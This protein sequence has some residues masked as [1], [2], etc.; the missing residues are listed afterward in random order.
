MKIV[1]PENADVGVEW[2]QED[3]LPKHPFVL[4]YQTAEE[5]VGAS[6]V[7]HRELDEE[8]TFMMMLSPTIGQGEGKITDEQILP[9][10]VVFCV[11]TSGS[12]IDGNKME[13]A[14]EALAYCVKQLRPKDRFNI[15]DFSTGVRAFADEGL[16]EADE[17]NRAKAQRYINKLAPRGG[18][19]IQ[20]ALTTSLEKLGDSDRLKMVLFATDGLPTI[21]ERDPE[22]ILRTMAKHNTNDVRMFVF[23]EGFDVNTKLLD[24]LAINHRGEADYILPEE[25]I[26]KKISSFFDRVGSPIMT[27][28]KV[29]FE[30][31]DA[32]DVYPAQI[33]DIFKGEQVILYGRY[34]NHGPHKVKVTG[35]IN[36]EQ[37]TLEYTLDFPEVS[38]D[39]KNAFVQRLWAGK[40]VDFLLDELRKSNAEDKELVEEITYLAKRYGIVTPY[41][42][43]LM[44]EDLVAQGN[45]Q[46]TQQFAGRLKRA[47]QAQ[48][49]GAALEPEAKKEAVQDAAELA[50][51]RRDADRSRARTA[52]PKT[53]GPPPRAQGRPGTARRPGTHRRARCI[54]RV[55]RAGGRPPRRAAR[56]RPC[57]RGRAAPAACSRAPPW[58]AGWCDTRTEA[59]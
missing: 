7:A 1:E 57:S 59:C 56:D 19:A 12:M 21:G 8:G 20:D 53:E 3:Y 13:Q 29:T 51:L 58:C 40:K 38:E 34:N 10:D 35:M 18:T 39:D 41:T 24:F 14:R 16:V 25:D 52:R 46:L 47:A 45:G 31:L 50:N 43:F 48:A 44:A 4:Y 17:K 22:A 15:I 55:R 33:P 9:K 23:G 11:D 36:G 26:T 6:L 54:C 28:L 5:E 49:P 2:S 37:K 27:D 32:K 42:S 30:G